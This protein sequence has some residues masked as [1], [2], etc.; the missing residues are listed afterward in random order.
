[1]FGALNIVLNSLE[2]KQVK[3]QNWCNHQK[4]DNLN[5]R[6]SE[7]RANHAIFII[8]LKFR[9]GANDIINSH[10]AHQHIVRSQ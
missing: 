1:M 6:P 4:R 2:R 5:K 3:R 8:F 10:T 9:N 7:L